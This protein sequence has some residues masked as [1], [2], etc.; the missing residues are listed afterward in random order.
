[1]I[2]QFPLFISCPRNMEYLLTDELT[3][4][5]LNVSKTTPMGVYGKAGL[6]TLYHICLWTR[7]ANR[8]QLILVEGEVTNKQ[9]LYDLCCQFDWLS[10]FT[11]DKTIAIEFHGQSP[12]IN[13][14]MYGAQLVK[15]A[16]VDF[17]KEQGERPNVDRQQPNIRL[18]AFLKKERLSVSLD[19]V[20][21]SLHQRGYRQAAG[22]A[23]IKENVAAGILVRANWPVMAEQG[24]NFMDP[25]CGSGTFLIEAALM[26]ANRAP[27]LLR[28]DQALCHWLGHD[29]DLWQT[30]RAKACEQ[31]RPIA[32]KIVGYDIDAKILAMARQNIAAA[33]LYESIIIE[34]RA[35][36]DFTA[37]DEVGLVVANPP[38]G[39]RLQEVLTLIPTYQALGEALFQ[40]CQG[41]QAVVLTAAPLLA[42]AIGLRSHK[43][44]H[45]YNG[46]LRVVLYCFNMD[47]NNQFK[48]TQTD[49][50]GQGMQALQNRLQKNYKHLKK[51]RQRQGITCYRLYDADLPEYAC[52]VDIYNDWAHVQEYVPPKSV[53]SHKAEQRVLEM[54]QLL[55]PVAKIP[56]DHII[57][58][59][60]QRQ[61][62]KQQYQVQDY[63]FEMMVVTEGNAKFLVNL[64]DYLDTGLF[65]DHRPLRLQ[66]ASELAGKRFLNCF[67]YTATA[68]VQAA[69]GGAL[70]T[71]VDLSNTYL[72][73]ARKNFRLNKIDLSQHEFV[74]ADCSV[75][76]PD[77]RQKYDT[78]FLDPPSFSNSKR[79]QDTFD[80]QRD[81]VNLIDCAMQ[82]LAPQGVLYFSNNL[83]KFKLDQSLS[84][85]YQIQDITFK[86]IDEDFK[87]SANVHHCFRLIKLNKRQRY[88]V[89]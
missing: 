18:H 49:A 80:V 82:L 61:K 42:K 46:P 6:Q 75:W 37:M 81:H 85:R 54:L 59:Q 77:C 62:G 51:W 3:E 17:F 13:N 74:Q 67:C 31:Q 89:Q 4:L 1:M 21:Y 84:E 72:D 20:G 30:I 8:V 15:D 36:K 12:F 38:Y 87:H 16:V 34:Q 10:V 28:T 7:L 65:L 52:A 86:T 47:S 45:F 41:W 26:A 39:E 5:G 48:T 24:F 68:S 14:T 27:G 23:P 79:M 43:Q 64:R 2:Q 58:K 9:Q 69:L 40:H 55:P 29:E 73:W 50:L 66:F 33:S 56:A 35:I 88:L 11:P 70:T 44:Y 83:R 53:P 71:N 22:I 32:N 63:S 19:L 60:R 76:L 57:L 25:F 78:I